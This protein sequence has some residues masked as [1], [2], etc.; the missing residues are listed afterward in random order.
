MV[1][2]VKV[3]ERLVVAG[4]ADGVVVEIVASWCESEGEG[5]EVCLGIESG[6]AVGLS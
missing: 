4:K 2:V 1:M 6:G 3:W 5:E